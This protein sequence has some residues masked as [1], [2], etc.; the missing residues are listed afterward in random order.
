MSHGDTIK[1]L[2]EGFKIIASTPSVE[3]AAFE[4]ENEP[5]YGIQ[6]HPEVTHT[7]EGNQLLE[8]LLS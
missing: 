5:T 3:V 1:T 2:P 8:K 4:I 6:F 7:L